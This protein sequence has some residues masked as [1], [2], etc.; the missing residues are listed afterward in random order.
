MNSGRLFEVEP[1]AANQYAVIHHGQPPL[2][3]ALPDG[4][5]VR[6]CQVDATKAIAPAILGRHEP[7]VGI[8]QRDLQAVGTLL[9]R[10]VQDLAPTLCQRLRVVA[11]QF[12]T[13]YPGCQA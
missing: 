9:H 12:G 4:F 10:T 6:H 5:S 8:I 3:A 2:T 11:L 13:G 7:E 1:D